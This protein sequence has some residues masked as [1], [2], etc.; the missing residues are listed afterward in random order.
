M[1]RPYRRTAVPVALLTTTTVLFLLTRYVTPAFA[2]ENRVHQRVPDQGYQLLNLMRRGQ[3]LPAKV[4]KELNVPQPQALTARPDGIAAGEEARWQQFVQEAL[5]AIPI[6]DELAA[7]LPHPNHPSESC[8]YAYPQSG[9]P[10]Q[11]LSSLNSCLASEIAFAPARDWGTENSSR[12][13][14]RRGYNLGDTDATEFY[15]DVPNK[16]TGAV[17]GYWAQNVDEELDETHLTWRPSNVLFLSTVNDI[18][19][20]ATEAG[21]MMF[22]VPVFC[23]SDLL[24]GNISGCWEGAVDFSHQVNPNQITDAVLNVGIGDIRGKDLEDWGIP[25]LTGFWHFV[26]PVPLSPGRFNIM[27]GMRISE[28]ALAEPGVF[29]GHW[30]SLDLLALGVCDVT[31]FSMNPERSTGVQR[32][33]QYA[34]GP[35]YRTNSDWVS[36]SVAHVEFEPMDNVGRYGWDSSDNAKHNSARYLG[37]PVH[38]AVDATV[39][40]HVAGVLGWHHAAWESYVSN[41]WKDIFN[42]TGKSPGNNY[43]HYFDFQG[44][45]KEAYRYWV[46]LGEH[47]TADMKLPVAPFIE[48]L[49]TETIT[50]PE[51]VYGGVFIYTGDNPRSPD[52]HDYSD[53]QPFA[54]TLLTRA[55]GA[56]LALMVTASKYVDLSGAQQSPCKCEEGYARYGQNANGRLIHTNVC[57]ACNTGVFTGLGA[58]LDGEC[59]AAC[60]Q[61]KP[62]SMPILDGSAVKCLA[63][64]ASGACTGVSCPSAGAPFVKDGACVAECTDGQIVAFNRL[65]QDTCPSGQAPDAAGFCAPSGLT[66]PQCTDKSKDAYFDC[67]HLRGCACLRA[68]DCNSLICSLDGICLGVTGETCF[69]DANC[70]SGRCVAGFCGE[71]AFGLPCVSTTDCMSLKCDGQQSGQPGHCGWGFTGEGCTAN[72]GCASD[73]CRGGVCG[74]GHGGRPCNAATDCLSHECLP[75]TQVGQIKECAIELGSPCETSALPPATLLPCAAPGSCQCGGL[76]P[77]GGSTP[78][79]C[80]APLQ[81]S[82]ENDSQCC[83]GI[84]VGNHCDSYRIP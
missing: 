50:E 63:T 2:Y 14:L 35:T 49:A 30:D 4:A 7:D 26:R 52:A 45:L 84:C 68:E 28:A 75:P 62:Y 10:P 25:N 56:A 21:I 33:P 53:L 34:D 48:L 41:A 6:L 31:G 70:S 43:V 9:S 38:T 83:S 51:S 15:Q 23:F 17:L 61:D 76:P 60:P 47:S 20:Y 55:T 40:H 24:D 64:C 12:C 39:P 65:C 44:I 5:A 32:Y 80:C 19:N 79:H 11:N 8:N 69:E 58:W 66:P 73:S 77:S 72:G 81:T 42:D 54:R 82:C 59:V 16:L 13:Y 67:C 1:L 78:C 18:A 29:F 71:G 22:A 57:T 36:T 74:Q 27:P 46:W 37:W 3:F